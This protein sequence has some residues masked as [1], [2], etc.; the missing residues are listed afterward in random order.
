MTTPKRATARGRSFGAP[1]SSGHAI[2]GVDK[3]PYVPEP[4]RTTR[5]AAGRTASE[6]PP[7]PAVARTL[8][9]PEPV[10]RPQP[11][12]LD[13]GELELVSTVDPI[14][15]AAAMRNRQE[16][17]VTLEFTVTQT[18]SVRDPWVTDAEPADL[19]DAAAIAA[20]KQWRFKPRVANGRAVEVR[21]A[22]TLRFNVDR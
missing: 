5:A 20:V 14:Y 12:Y 6:S 2:A 11:V 15:P 9:T 13:P 3:R 21:S 19:F 22:V 4:A 1:I 17:W 16:G 8:V 18:G 7:V 10:P